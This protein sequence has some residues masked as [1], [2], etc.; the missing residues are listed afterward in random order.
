MP[1]IARF[2][3]IIVSMYWEAG[4]PHSVPHFHVIQGLA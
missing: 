4:D 2:W 3:G 1:E